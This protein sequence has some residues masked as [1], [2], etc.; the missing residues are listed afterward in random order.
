[1]AIY[2]LSVKCISRSHG[3]SATAAAA[4][5]SAVKIHDERTGELHDYAQKSGVSYTLL[6]LPDRAPEWA[7][8]REKLWNEAE[9]AEVRR[10]S[11]V[12]RE[13]EVALPEELD[14]K[15]CRA[16]AVELAR[17][18]VERHG[19]AA[20]VAIHEPGR[21]GDLRNHHAHILC[22]TRRLAREGFTVKTRELDE[23][24]TGEVDRWRERWA[25][26]TNE[27]LKRAGLDV[28]VDHRSLADQGIDRSPTKH[29]GPVVAERLRRGKDSYVVERIRE[30]QRED[31]ARRL[32]TAAE[33]G[34]LE[35]EEKGITRA[36]LDT[37]TTL[38]RALA[39][40]HVQRK[41]P[42]T[43]PHA[44]LIRAPEERRRNAQALW[45]D[46]RTRASDPGDKAAESRQAS[47]VICLER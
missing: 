20:D 45:L 37:E 17:C 46:A 34:Q 12:A 47:I 19:C 43:Y 38:A 30:E 1:M 29:F 3:R 33:R 13:F 28:R 6:V 15:G 31:I 40:R 23:R 41:G 39:D 4:Y 2:H 8:D 5:R 35:R 27:H 36:I 14:E 44:E 18:I 24:K 22:T 42:E 32:A 11:T 9:L 7:R 26:L 16:L 21:E 10:D 25:T